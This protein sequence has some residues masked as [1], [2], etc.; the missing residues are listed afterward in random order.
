[1]DEITPEAN[2]AFLRDRLRQRLLAEEPAALLDVGCGRGELLHACRLAGVPALGLEVS[3]ERAA[4]VRADGGAVILGRGEQLPCADRSVA[5]VVMRHAAHHLS[6]PERGVRELARVAAHGVV[7][8]EPWRPIDRPEQATALALDEWCKRHDRRR[9]HDHHADVPAARLTSWL[10]SA[11][12]FDVEVTEVL[13]G[14][15]LPPE[16]VQ[17]DLAAAI[18]DLSDDAPERRDLGPLLARAAST[19]VGATGSAIVVARRR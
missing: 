19:G 12:A 15:C 6:D 5:W 1:M 3:A 2:G 16:Q 10:Q 9:G 7:V 18:S 8:A 17:A 11:G 13:R 4:A 14:A